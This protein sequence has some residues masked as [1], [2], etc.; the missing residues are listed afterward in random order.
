MGKPLRSA[1]VTV[2][3]AAGAVVAVAPVG[4]GAVGSTGI[5]GESVTSVPREDASPPVL[6]LPRPRDFVSTVDHPFLPFVPGTRWVYRENEGG[7]VQRIVVTVVHRTRTIEGVEATVVHDVATVE[8]EVVEDTFDWYAQDKAGNVWYLGEN[9][10]EYA[11]DGSVSTD[12][13]W[14]AGEHGAAAG[15]V[16]PADPVTGREYRQEYRPGE[17]E[18]MARVVDQDT[19]VKVPF[20]FFGHTWLTEETNPLE[21]RVSELKF[22]ARGIG[23][24]EEDAVSPHAGRAVLIEL[25][26]P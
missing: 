22:Y 15:I 5:R 11:E 3:L 2:A 8:G 26:R 14:E 4:S 17:A 10:K 23:V 12:G 19:I 7:E 24:V 1:A 13:S 20:G 18:D 6:P 16:M 25:E 21:P 9:T